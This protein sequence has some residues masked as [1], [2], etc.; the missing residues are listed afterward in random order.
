[1]CKIG[2][3]WKAL[4]DKEKEKWNT[5][6]KNVANGTTP[7]VDKAGKGGKAN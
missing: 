1:M 2:A 6:A 7:A 4:S 5:I 3:A